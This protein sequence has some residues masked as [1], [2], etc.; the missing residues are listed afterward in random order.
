[1]AS[2]APLA[3]LS[4]ALL[5]PLPCAGL[6][7]QPFTPSLVAGRSAADSLAGLTQ[8]PWP[9]KN[10]NMM[11]T[12]QGLGSAVG[13]SNL[14]RA[15]W[16][17]D[18]E[19]SEGGFYQSPVI[20][21]RQ[22]AIFSSVV[23]NLYSMAPS[24]KLNWKVKVPQEDRPS[25]QM[26]TP[27]LY[28]DALYTVDGQG[29]AVSVSLGSGEVLW[30]ARYAHTSGDDSWSMGV[31]LASS[32]IFSVGFPDKAS[33]TCEFSGTHVYAH[34]M[35][36][37]RVKWSYPLKA[38]ACNVMPAVFNGTVFFND[39]T[40]GVYG[41]DVATGAER[42]FQPGS[43]D[44]T[45][46]TTA[47]AA[48]GENGMLYIPYNLGRWRGALRAFSLATGEQRW[49][50]TFDREANSG[51]AVYRDG[52]GKLRVALGISNNAG[53][54]ALLPALDVGAA[55]VGSVYAFDAESGE[56][57]WEFNP[58]I[59]EHWASA[60][61]SWLKLCLPDSFSNPSVDANGMLYIGWMGGTVYALNGTSGKEVSHYQIDSGI[62]GAPGIGEHM[63]VA[64]SCRRVVG[65]L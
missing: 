32:T 12:G 2:L 14:S 57:V 16:V 44:N 7:R 23:G 3:R 28:G 31:D 45:S 25:G 22:N 20:D 41:V 5:L 1:M 21:R 29:Y 9:L 26:P 43:D 30:R 47:G 6:W 64:T 63:L 35:A 39:Q 10:G 18:P 38:C 65:I 56:Q 60:E 48:I 27:L 24:G 49:N 36:D 4:L 15:A 34:D 46:F 50:Q 8:H 59:W 55:F 13:P 53:P 19:D 33:I 40:G 61:S 17:L 42:W 58:P 54:P 11:R 62:Q 51:P 52:S 37:G